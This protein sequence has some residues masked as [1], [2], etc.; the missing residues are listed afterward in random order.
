MLNLFAMDYLAP[1]AQEVLSAFQNRETFKLLGTIEGEMEIKPI[2][3]T[4]NPP[5][6]GEFICFGFKVLKEGNFN[7]LKM[8]SWNEKTREMNPLKRAFI[9]KITGEIKTKILALTLAAQ[10]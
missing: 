1:S 6:S 7:D 8:I 10:R 4:E 3:V 9:K 5:G 2:D